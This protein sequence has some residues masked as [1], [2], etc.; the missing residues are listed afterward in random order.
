MNRTTHPRNY[1]PTWTTSSRG[2]KSHVTV[3]SRDFCLSKLLTSSTRN[4]DRFCCTVYVDVEFV[5]RKSAD[6]S[7]WVGRWGWVGLGLIYAVYYQPDSPTYVLSLETLSLCCYTETILDFDWDTTFK[8]VL[9]I[10]KFDFVRS[11]FLWSIY[12]GTTF[13]KSYLWDLIPTTM[14]KWAQNEIIPKK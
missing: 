13:L 10:L 14:R 3:K 8:K 9:K 7:E 4:L 1:P 11:E 5:V 12:L 6:R 2:Q